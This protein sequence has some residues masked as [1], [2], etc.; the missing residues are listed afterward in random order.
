M[1][2][3]IQSQNDPLD[4]LEAQMDRLEST[5]N[6]QILKLS[7]ILDISNQLDRNQ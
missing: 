2:S 7:I 5:M 3:V 6:E 4:M 1:K